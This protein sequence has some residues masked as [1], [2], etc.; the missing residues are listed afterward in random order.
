MAAIGGGASLAHDDGDSSGLPSQTHNEI[1]GGAIELAV[2]ARSIHGGIHLHQDRLRMPRPAQLPSSG[3]VCGRSQDLAALDAASCN[4]A[5]VISG[6]PGIGK[7]A[8]AVYWAHSRREKFPDGQLFADLRGHAPD[9]PAG[10]SEVLARFVRAL[11]IPPQD[12]PAELAE[13]TALYRS[14][15]SGLRIVVVLDDAISAA[16]VR[17]LQPASAESMMLVTSRWRLTSLVAAGAKALQID[18]LDARAAVDLLGRVLGEERV[19]AELA[20]A[21]EL[22]SLCAF[23]P[24]PLRISAARLAVHPKWQLSELVAVLRSQ[25]SRLPAF[26]AGDDMALV[27][28]LNLSYRALPADAAKMYRLMGLFP[29]GSFGSHIAAAAAELPLEAARDSL[30]LLADANMLDDAVGGRY[31]FHDLIRL[32]ALAMGEEEDSEVHRNAAIHRM[33]EWY[34]GAVIYAGHIIAPYRRNLAY[35]SHGGPPESLPFSN[36]GTALDWLERELPNLTAAASFAADHGSPVLAWQLVDALWPLFLRR[37]LYPDRLALDRIGLAAARNAGDNEAEAKMLGRY[38]L[39]L[40]SIGQLNEAARCA[41]QA[42]SI[43]RAAG[44][45]RRVAGCLRRLALVEQ[46]RG[47]PE[48][49]LAFFGQALEVYERLGESRAL[50]LTLTDM[51]GVLVDSHRAAEAIEYLRRAREIIGESPDRYNQARALATLGRA[52]TGIGSF[53]GAAAALDEALHAMRKVHSLT[54]EAQVLQ[55]LG[56]LAEVSAQ[57]ANARQHYEAA[58]EILTRIASPRAQELTERLARLL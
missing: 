46:A 7:T 50:A 28:S 38:G 57:P 15:T 40:T 45:H 51:G 13:L 16:Q 49:A 9:G 37:G 25:R 8:L 35:D 12:L 21:Q 34:L 30:G 29:G 1:G 6:P 17:P 2:Q 47:R 26:A 4:Q 54:G 33:L 3:G 41:E 18:P 23:F 58:K 53:P 43:W 36:D 56:E 31:R 11:G 32:H 27:T 19:A 48:E 10:P 20:A 22:A 42:M 5:V 55:L 52:L 39:V 44:N 24:L 14:A